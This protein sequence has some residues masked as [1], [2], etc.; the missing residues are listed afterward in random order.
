MKLFFITGSANKFA[1]V[2]VI[3]PQVE[4][5][6]I[7]LDEIQELDAHK[8]IAAKIFQARRNKGNTY[9]VEDT[10]LYLDGMQGLP[11]PL[12]KWFLKS[13]GPEGIFKL[14]QTFG[15]AARAKTIIGYADEKGKI[16]F[17]E[18]ETKGTIVEQCGAAGFRWDAIFQ[19]DGSN[20]TFAELTME[21]K[22]AYSMRSIAVQKLQAYLENHGAH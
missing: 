16:E 10:S 21:E 22:N 9:M 15:S 17:F 14:A 6:D 12:I 5:L 1:E 11:G 3:L 2:K 18:G 20:K 13:I 19:P 8:I 7:E 4:Q